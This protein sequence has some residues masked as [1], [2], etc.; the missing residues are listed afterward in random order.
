MIWLANEH[1]TEWILFAVFFFTQLFLSFSLKQRN[2]LYQT[3]NM[4]ESQTEEER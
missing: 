4:R 3:M 1:D 2:N